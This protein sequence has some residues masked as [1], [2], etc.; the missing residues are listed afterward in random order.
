MSELELS[1]SKEYIDKVEKI[2][3]DYTAKLTPLIARSRNR[4]KYGEQL[5]DIDLEI[6]ELL[7]DIEKS[8]KRKVSVRQDKRIRSRLKQIQILEETVRLE[9][10]PP[11]RKQ[12]SR[13]VEEKQ[14]EQKT[15]E[16][17]FKESE[18][19]KDGDLGENYIR[20]TRL[21]EQ[22]EDALKAKGQ[23]NGSK[24]DVWEGN[25]IQSGKMRREDLVYNIKKQSV[26]S[27]QQVKGA[28]TRKTP[29]RRKKK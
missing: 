12:P 3:R 23:I 16:E 24:R 6:T 1:D 20:G 18:P 4:D 15:R 25:V 5:I 9:I 14:R 11:T 22:E 21:T 26:S 27:Y 10:R 28:K 19:V 8:G 7:T 17:E 13:P 29:T 2:Q